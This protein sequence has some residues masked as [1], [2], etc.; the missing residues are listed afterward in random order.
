MVGSVGSKFLTGMV[1]LLSGIAIATTTSSSVQGATPPQS[2][3]APASSTPAEISS[4]P[5]ALAMAPSSPVR[6]EIP[7]IAV[8]SDLMHL[9]LRDDGT[10]EVPPE[11]FPAGW[12]AGSPTPGELGPAIIAGHVDWGG[13]PGVF[14]D[15]RDLQPGAD[16]I[17]ARE[18]GSTAV[19]RISSVQQYPKDEFPSELVY[20]DL[21]YA[22]LRL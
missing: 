9:G 18:D 5:S 13:A 15:L 20:G 21:D 8:L 3:L 14:F 16:V 17:I 19:F 11:G 4:P 6:I 7:S 22:G 10:L 2:S 12:Y 1:V